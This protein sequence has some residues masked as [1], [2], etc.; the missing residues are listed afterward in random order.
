MLLVWFPDEEETRIGLPRNFRSGRVCQWMSRL[1]GRVWPGRE[2]SKISPSPP[3]PHNSILLIIGCN[4]PDNAIGAA[5][6]IIFWHVYI[7]MGVSTLFL[8]N[9]KRRHKPN[10][11]HCG[12]FVNIGYNTQTEKRAISTCNHFS[13]P[14]QND[15]SESARF[16][17]HDSP[18][19]KNGL[20]W[21]VKIYLTDDQET[22]V[23]WRDSQLQPA[24]RI[25]A[26]QQ[27]ARCSP[28]GRGSR[29][30]LSVDSRFTGVPQLFCARFEFVRIQI[31]F[32]IIWLNWHNM[33]RCKA[34]T[35]II[36]RRRNN[37]RDYTCLWLW[38]PLETEVPNVKPGKF[39][40]NH[41]MDLE[42]FL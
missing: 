22:S 27:F 5:L 30:F 41:L 18:C 31:F 25:Q 11:R 38:W 1:M 17:N 34:T 29:R 21:W 19:C 13:Y 35:R 40:D 36:F 32:F 16:K 23:G 3:L 14:Y 37:F 6:H 10:E 7:L 8:Q 28:T 4:S 33:K 9:I 39:V 24:L 15:K 12:N 2:S 26:P 42:H 20:T